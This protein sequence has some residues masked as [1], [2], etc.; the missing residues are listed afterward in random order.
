M[1]DPLPPPE[2]SHRKRRWHANYKLDRRFFGISSWSF[3]LDVDRIGIPQPLRRFPLTIFPLAIVV[4]A[5]LL[6]IYASQFDP[7]ASRG[8]ANGFWALAITGLITGL[9]WLHSRQ[10]YVQITVQPDY[11]YV[12]RFGWSGQD[13]VTIKRDEFIGVADR[14]VFM[15]P[16]NG[17]P[18]GI[19]KVIELAHT[20]TRLN[21][22]LVI[23]LT[24]DDLS[25][26]R[27][28]YAERLNIPLFNRA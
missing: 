8:V 21:I 3:R 16:G 11:F 17:Q 28:R 12:E 7:L 9:D 27:D 23:S 13:Q 20:D 22:P 6:L 14:E 1:V 25:G 5:Q 4:L 15:V 24:L 19:L 18:L 2:R 26:L 10:N